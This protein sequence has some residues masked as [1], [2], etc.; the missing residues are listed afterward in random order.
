MSD[1]L[2]SNLKFLKSKLFEMESTYENKVKVL[3]KRNNALER[4]AEKLDHLVKLQDDIIQIECDGKFYETSK[5]TVRNCF[6]DNILKDKINTVNNNVNPYYTSYEKQDKP[7]YYIDM[8]RKGLKLMLKIL[9]FYSFDENKNKNYHIY[10]DKTE[11]ELLRDQLAYFFKND[12]MLN[13][14]I[15]IKN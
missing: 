3:E 10:S 4:A 6:L 13:S 9:R 14:L 5:T 7:S 15:I 12:D 8:S 2:L 1:D 11:E